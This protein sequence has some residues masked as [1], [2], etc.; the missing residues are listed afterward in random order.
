MYFQNC[1]RHL[2]IHNNA[3]VCIFNKNNGA[4]GEGN[5]IIFFPMK[6]I[7]LLVEK[8]AGTLSCA[9]RTDCRFVVPVFFS[10]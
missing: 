1:R 9:P 7:T 4:L 5:I 10:C 3:E 8:W 6:I 2:Q